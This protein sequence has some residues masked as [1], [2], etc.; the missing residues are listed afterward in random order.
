MRVS[1]ARRIR[2]GLVFD[3]SL[4]YCRGVLRGIKRFAAA[5]PRWTFALVAPEA[6]EMEN[7]ARLRPAGLIAHVF[8]NHLAAVLKELRKPIVNV[9]GV[10]PRLRIPTIHIDDAAI[11]YLAAQHLLERGFRNF[12]FVGNSTFA[13]SVKQEAAFCQAV[14]RV[15]YAA[16]CFY[17]RSERSFHPHGRL[18][19][20]DAHIR[21]WLKSLATPIGIFASNDL[22]GVQLTE[23][24]HEVGL[25]VPEDVAVVGVDNDSLMCELSRPSLSSVA[26]PS[27]QVG[28]EAAAL[29]DR[30]LAGARAPKALP[31]L[32]PLG[33]V[34]RQSSGILAVTDQD[35]AAAIRFIRERAHTAIGVNDVL[36]EVP[37][38]RR[39]LE[40][41]FHCV[42]RRGVA[43]EIRRVHLERA[44]SLLATT[45]LPIALVAEQ[46]GFSENKHLS[47]V[48]RKEF[49]LSP[50][51]YRQQV[52]GAP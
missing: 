19:A 15:G 51:A 25:R 50:T 45:W 32:A 3:R 16:A 8:S 5:K 10:V 13:Y 42:L 17:D 23:A 31:L 41:R 12:A 34:T 44:K 30:L 48:F 7:L 47:V 6:Q 36:R 24:C 46:A 4:D 35:V 27:E 22:W 37:I 28:Y 2:I 43:Q 52:Q 1:L 29:L 26:I 38:G 9:S 40:R 39:S 11:G 49:G 21:A 20:F 14:S 18:W 33:I